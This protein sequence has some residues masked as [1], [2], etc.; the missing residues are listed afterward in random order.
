MRIVPINSVTSGSVLANNIFSE[1]GD[2]LL[3]KGVILTKNLIDRIVDNGVYTVYIDDGYTDHEIVD[4]IQ[5]EV[6]LKAMKAIKETFTQIENYNK[7]L[8]SQVD[9]FSKKIQ[10]KSMGKYVSK[11]KGIAEFIVDDISNSR[12]LMINLVDIKNLNN[13]LYEHSLS[14]AILSTVVGLE[15]RL[16]KHQLY[17]L[18][19][20]AMVHDIGKLF[21]NK[22]L[23]SQSDPYNVEE[24]KAVDKHTEMGYEYLKENYNFE[25]PA[26]LISLQHHECFDGTGYPKGMQGD[27][28]HIFSRIVAVCNTYDMMVSDT[29]QQAAI[30]VNEALEYIMGNAGS[31]F[32]FNVVEIFSRKVNPYPIGTLVE[33]SNGEIHLVIGDNPNFPLRPIVQKVNTELR[34]LENKAIDL[35]KVTDIVISK[36]HY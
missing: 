16:N 1:N 23:I 2:I 7:Q 10:M 15:M 27:S 3:K 5:P 19:L 25:A 35:M 18:F 26:R 12:Q 32:D 13:Y 33:L 9:S 28:I 4:I 31:C 6:R 11:L 22:N 21:I 14:V 20:G 8:E 36:I 30:P 29:P 24:Q 17:N 34:T